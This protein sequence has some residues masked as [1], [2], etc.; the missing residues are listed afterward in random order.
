MDDHLPTIEEQIAAINNS[1]TIGEMMNKGMALDPGLTQD[2]SGL[3]EHLEEDID[4]TAARG[5]AR[6]V[7]EAGQSDDDAT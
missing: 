1:E 4:E 7:A 2:R 5:H 6:Q 3:I